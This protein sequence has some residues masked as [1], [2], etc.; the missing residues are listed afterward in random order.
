MATQNK[1]INQFD[2]DVVLTGNELILIMCDGV[3]KNMELSNVKDFVLSGETTLSNLGFIIVPGIINQDVVLPDDSIVYHYGDLEMGS[4]YTLTIPS[5]TT[6]EFIDQDNTFVTGNTNN[7]SV[8]VGGLDNIIDPSA[9]NAVVIGGVGITGTSS[10]TVYVPNLNI[11]NLTTGDTVSN[12]GVDANGNIIISQLSSLSDLGFNIIPK[13]TKT[14]H[15]NIVLPDNADVT[16]PTP[17]I[18]DFGKTI[19]VPTDTVLIIT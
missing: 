19:I 14:I 10:D 9:N 13:P 8:L 6:L 11:N 3:T 17:L 5:G 12:L 16:Y 7:N 18:M 15:Q 1:R 4:G 2:T